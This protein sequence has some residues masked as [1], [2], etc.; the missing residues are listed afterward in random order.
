M[1]EAVSFL[2]QAVSK[3]RE[4]QSWS[5]DLPETKTQWMYVTC[6]SRWQR[7][8]V[9]Q[10]A[11]TMKYLFSKLYSTGS[12]LEKVTIP[13]IVGWRDSIDTNVVRWILQ[14]NTR[15]S[16]TCTSADAVNQEGR[17][18]TLLFQKVRPELAIC[19]SMTQVR[20]CKN[21]RKSHII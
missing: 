18:P 1:L 7:G 8:K 2:V 9:S 11:S 14:V 17:F 13:R 5:L 21:I 16:W 4:T 12:Y 19:I 20:C 10:L 3:S 15:Y 6:Y